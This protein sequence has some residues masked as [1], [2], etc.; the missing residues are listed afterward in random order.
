M[1]RPS[2][3]ENE[4]CDVAENVSYAAEIYKVKYK[5]LYP[6]H[7]FKTPEEGAWDLHTYGK[8]GIGTHFEGGVFHL[9]QGRMP[10]NATLFHNI[11]KGIRNNTFD[12]NNML[13]CRTPL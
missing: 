5:T 9:Y 4:T 11:C 2:F 10:N 8:Y 12:Y 7:Y 1:G 3:C 13:P 6:T